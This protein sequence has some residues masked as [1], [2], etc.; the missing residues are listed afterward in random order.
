[1]TDDIA[2]SVD[3]GNQALP[4]FAAAVFPFLLAVRY[5]WAVIFPYST[6]GWDEVLIVILILELPLLIVRAIVVRIVDSG[7]SDAKVRLRKFLFWVSIAFAL[8]SAIFAQ[9]LLG[10]VVTHPHQLISGVVSLGIMILN[11]AMLLV[12]LRRATDLDRARGDAVIAD[13]LDLLALMYNLFLFCV[14]ASII[15]GPISLMTGVLPD[16]PTDEQLL[17]ALREV[18]FSFATIYFFFQT[19]FC[20]WPYTSRFARTRRRLFDAW[21]VKRFSTVGATLDK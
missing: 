14:V 6:R 15:A 3:E 2:P 8:L 13:W 1:M 10:V 19:L 21:W 9:A 7:E 16:S 12:F 20:A 11:N 5:G 17:L 18:G 4:M